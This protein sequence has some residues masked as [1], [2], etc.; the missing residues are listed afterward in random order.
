MQ[1]R[2]N[3]SKMPRSGVVEEET[4]G[5]AATNLAMGASMDRAIE[6]PNSLNNHEGFVINPQANRSHKLFGMDG[7]TSNRDASLEGTQSVNLM[8]G[9]G[10]GFGLDDDLVKFTD[11]LN[12]ILEEVDGSIQPEVAL[13]Y[14]CTTN[15]SGK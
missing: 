9:I 5:N 3:P 2:S 6:T 8:G 11:L 15:F 4:S 7:Q 12:E 1:Q 13:Q 10:D 14:V